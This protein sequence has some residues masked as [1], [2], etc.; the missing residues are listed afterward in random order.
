M[1]LRGTAGLIICAAMAPGRSRIH[2]PKFAL[3]G[4]PN[5]LGNLRG[6][7]VDVR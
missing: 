1:D 2:E 7:G 4:Y 6:I 3:R 5:F